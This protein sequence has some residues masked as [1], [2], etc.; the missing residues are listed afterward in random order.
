MMGLLE[1]L[2]TFLAGDKAE[3]PGAAAAASCC[4][5]SY[6]V[7]LPAMVCISPEIRLGQH[8]P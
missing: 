2:Q 7:A 3:S 4:L 6:G 8:S 1:G 5:R